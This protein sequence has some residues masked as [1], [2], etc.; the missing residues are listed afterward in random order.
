MS[1][2]NE[3]DVKFIFDDNKELFVSKNAIT[4]ISP[5]F[6]FK[7]INN[8]ENY[9]I[10]LPKYIGYNDLD[11][12][13]K[14]FQ[15]YISR[16]R[17]FNFDESFISIKIILEGYSINIS[18]LIQI[19]E[20]LENNSFSI[21]LI[22]DCIL[23]ESK[24]NENI[25]DFHHK[26]NVDNAIILLYLSY[27]K[28]KEIN[29]I[30]KTNNPN[31]KGFNNLEEELE[32]TWLDL[33]IKSLE[34]IG[35]NLNYYFESNEENYANNKLWGF[36]KK[37]IDELYEKFCFNLITK[38]F[39]IKNEDEEEED[40]EI[41]LNNSNITQNYIEL[42]ELN[43]IINFLMKKRNQND[44]FSLLSNE[45]MR[46]ISEENIN[47][48][49]NLPNPTFILKINVNDIN[50]YYEEYPIDDTF[51]MNDNMKIIIV[52]YYKKNEDTFNV[53]LKLSKN[54]ND[55]G[56]IY[57][58]IITFLTLALV[59]EIDSR[60]I[61][62]KSLSHNKSMYEILKITNFTK[63]ISEKN[64]TEK[65]E[66]LTLKIFLKPCYIYIMLT[67]YLF[68]N[69]ENLY[70]NKN[71]S[72]LS[73]NLLNIIIQKKQ[74]IKSDDINSKNDKEIKNSNTDKI[75]SCLINWLNDEVNIGE[76]LSEII[77]NI[78]WEYASLPLLLEF[79]I[80]YS[81]HILSDDIEYIFSK[82]L[83]RILNK[84]EGNIN[85]ISKE[86]IHSIILSSKKINY[87]SMFCENKNIKKKFNLYELMNQKRNL[88]LQLNNNKIPDNNDNDND[89]E[90]E[91]TIKNS[92]NN[93]NNINN[94]YIQKK[95]KDDINIKKKIALSKENTNKN[96][97]NVSRNNIK[98]K[99]GNI[100]PIE[101]K[102]LNT[103][104][105][106][107]SI[108]FINNSDIC[109]NNYF[110]NCNNNFNIN[111]KLNDKIKK[112]ISDNKKKKV[113]I[114]QIKIRTN[115]KNNNIKSLKKYSSTPNKKLVKNHSFYTPKVKVK[116]DKFNSN[117][118]LNKTINF[119]NRKNMEKM[120]IK[121]KNDKYKKRN[122]KNNLSENKNKTYIYEGNSYLNFKK[123]YQK[124]NV[125]DVSIDNNNTK[126]D[127]KTKHISLLSELIKLNKKGK[128]QNIFPINKNLINNN[129]SVNIIKPNFQISIGNK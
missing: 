51:N 59:E 76:D 63:I 49:N 54:K 117:N 101:N 25:N 66:Y 93:S 35:K 114:S 23:T 16:L 31:R 110:T 109:Y 53:A 13:I 129:Q 8:N 58:D 30:D 94:I 7:N 78:K 98:I 28:L 79:L 102:L 86:I 61:N 40:K 107:N 29:S 90:N 97:N 41:E 69:L 99:T 67:N 47:E 112:I 100:T 111:I 33:F 72:K 27:N 122:N 43:K 123:Y 48:I 39:I 52:V 57:F 104:K 81:S 116:L 17:Q 70:T 4:E 108:S 68:Y 56:N 65:N 32:S 85:T 115:N 124:K 127:I 26:M 106:K 126:K 60:K 77:K 24:S 74:L 84:F 88:S 125:N 118:I 42:K 6:Y 20:Y 120:M 46:I 121:K 44:F 38:N 80:K 71:I 37:I 113:I 22:K 105:N 89:N 12:F 5:T 92:I 14:I 3:E 34:M 95:N 18:K 96:I 103:N 82:S 1:L 64:K 75:L 83:S 21:I 62:I 73:K 55:K 11:T 87:I 119:Q 50:N 128:Q 2:N 15:K 36:D 45:F 10:K 19:S 9:E 91:N